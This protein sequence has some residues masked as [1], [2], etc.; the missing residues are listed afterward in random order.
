MKDAYLRI[1]RLAQGV[2]EGYR[3]HEEIPLGTDSILIA[4]P[5]RKANT[6]A[7]DIAI[8]GDDYVSRTPVEL[9]YFFSVPGFFLHF[10]DEIRAR[11]LPLPV[12]NLLDDEVLGPG[13]QDV[14]GGRK[15]TFIYK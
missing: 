10:Q 11:F 9:G 15:D 5:G 12:R 14:H 7:P 2:I 3:E 8:V 13:F 1:E 4:R 6:I